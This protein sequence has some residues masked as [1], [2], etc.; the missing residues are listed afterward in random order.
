MSKINH[1]EIY[2]KYLLYSGEDIA[3]ELLGRKKPY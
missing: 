2:T 1:S 3:A